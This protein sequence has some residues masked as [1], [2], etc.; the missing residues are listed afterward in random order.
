MTP[1]IL[2]FGMGFVVAAQVGPI[3][4]LCA[5]SVLRGSLAV[6]LAI[7]LG[8]ALIDTAYA[9]AGV[10]GASAILQITAL[11]LT[12][13]LVGAAVIIWLGVR[14]LTTALRVRSGGELPAEAHSPARAFRVS[15][16]ATASN[17][18]TIASWG[19]IFTATASAHL[20]AGRVDLPLMLLGVGIGSWAWFSL[21]SVA[22][23]ALRR[24]SRGVSVRAM[25]LASSL[26]LVGFGGLMAWR[27]LRL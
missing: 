18:M 16:L 13:G 10:L 25:D 26:A 11:R 6:G 2:G 19:A 12:V 20:V 14:H 9:A 22:I 1:V 3:W 21:L 27:T 5:R 24:A 8:A 15:L 17:P 4:L 7:G 23:S